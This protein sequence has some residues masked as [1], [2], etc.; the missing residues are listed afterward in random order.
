MH[1]LKLILSLTLFLTL[2]SPLTI[3]Q[4]DSNNSR[5]LLAPLI[6]SQ[7][8]SQSLDQP[9]NQSS[10][11]RLNEATQLIDAFGLDFAE[12]RV[13][14]VYD[15]VSPS[16]VSITTQTYVPTFFFDLVPQDGAGSGFII[17]NQG[18]IVTNY[19]V[20]EGATEL[21]ITLANGITFPA[22]IVGFAERS[23][24]AIIKA[25]GATKDLFIPVT[26]GDSSTLKVGQRAIAIGNPFGEFGQ[27]LTTGVVSALNRS[28]Q[29]NDNETEINGVIQTDASINR[30]NSGGPLLDSS[31]RVIGIN[32][33]IFSP[34][35]TS[36]GI[37]FAVPIETLVKVLPDILRF[38][39]YRSPSL[40]IRAAYIINPEASRLL[41]LSVERGLL[42]NRL[43]QNSP[44]ISQGVRAA[45]Q[46]AIL[47]N[48]RIFIGGDVLIAVDGNLI[49][50]QSDLTTLLE[51]NY[52]VGDTVTVT[53]VRD[54]EVFDVT[55][56]LVSSN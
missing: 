14:N 53:L 52:I 2:T 56:Q 16:V 13:I 12:Q 32:T 31:G 51:N 24:L 22:D 6:S 47:N 44:L 54:R 20:V 36:S 46:E 15:E 9:L 39:Q 8:L 42:I 11:D 49:E 55:V 19:H 18:H 10:S 34:S 29:T 28:L 23:D 5:P 48:R 17:D 33:A 27:T 3:A 45:Q 7:P 21:F 43:D 38:G 25:R 40:G 41:D 37:G 26:F 1:R 35:G 4:N 30:G 50:E